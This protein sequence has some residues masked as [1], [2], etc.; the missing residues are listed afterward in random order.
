ML[1]II[2]LDI[3]V[4]I[5][6][7]KLYQIV[8]AHYCLII[9]FIFPFKNTIASIVCFYAKN[10]KIAKIR[11]LGPITPQSGTEFA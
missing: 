11:K 4:C 6:L 5:L 9:P 3:E 10:L 2:I 7:S 1:L 8:N